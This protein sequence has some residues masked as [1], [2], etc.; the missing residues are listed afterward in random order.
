MTKIAYSFKESASSARSARENLKIPEK[1][2]NNFINSKSLHF[3]SIAA[4]VLRT[5]T[6]QNLQNFLQTDS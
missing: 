3:P 2:K 4:S 5:R 1:N 6:I